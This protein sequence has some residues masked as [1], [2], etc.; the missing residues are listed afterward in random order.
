[1]VGKSFPQPQDAASIAQPTTVGGA[2][3]H[4]NRDTIHA[5]DAAN[6]DEA[7]ITPQKTR[8]NSF[9]SWSFPLIALLACTMTG[10]TAAIAFLSLTALPPE[11]DCAQSTD[12]DT[13]RGLLYCVQR[14][15]QSGEMDKVLEGLE[16]LGQW[17]P[18]DPLYYEAQDSLE[19]WSR[20]ALAVARQKLRNNE[21]D[22]A[23]ALVKKVP[24]S[25][26]LYT[27]AQELLGDWQDQSDQAGMMVSTAQEALKQK[28]W[29]QVSEQ[30]NKLGNLIAYAERLD[31]IRELS[32]Q[33]RV[34]KENN[35][36]FQS[37]L[38]IAE[39]NTPQA[40]GLALE[41]AGTIDQSTYVWSEGESTLKP[42][43]ER[44][45]N[46]SHLQWQQG[47]LGNIIT[48]AQRVSIFESLVPEANNLDTLA[49]AGKLA[50]TTDTKWEPSHGHLFSLLEATSAVRQIPASSQFYDKAQESLKSW[51]AQFSDVSHLQFAKMSAEV[52]WLPTVEWATNQA[53]A[54]STDRP[55]RVQAQTLAAHWNLELERIKDRRRLIWAS[56]LSEPGTRASLKMAITEA[57][58][59]ESDRP[60]FGEAQ[61]LIYGWTRDIQ[62]QEDQPYLAL[63]ESLAKQGEFREA[64]KTAAFIKPNRPLHNAARSA[65]NQWQQE[66]WAQQ[67][68]EQQRLAR[69]RP[70]RRVVQPV[71][72]IAKPKPQ[73]TPVASPARTR[74]R[75]TTPSPAITPAPAPRKRGTSSAPQ[76]P[77]VQ[78]PPAAP[79]QP[80]TPRANSPTPQNDGNTGIVTP[81]PAPTVSTPP[82]S[83]VLDQRDTPVNNSSPS[84]PPITTTPPAPVPTADSVNSPEPEAADRPSV[85][86]PA[87][88]PATPAPALVTP[89][90]PTPAPVPVAAPAPAPA[91]VA[92]PAP[93]PAPSPAPAPAPAPT[94]QV[95]APDSS[96]APAPTSAAPSS[97]PADSTSVSLNSGGAGNGGSGGASE[98]AATQ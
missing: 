17:T 23:I 89:V 78:S 2:A 65:I 26:P 6:V 27:D 18:A 51:E 59:V 80:S 58:K 71:V 13:D 73:A 29:D 57:E 49:K 77:A 10:G 4:D 37:V 16:I 93:A 43:A 42:L 56:K 7:L 86:A 1:M 36:I 30:I 8:E 72:T 61:G 20:R 96:P 12:I 53:R 62:K 81:N 5:P 21:L 52:G 79:A 25:S 97:A 74:S 75:A 15:A 85:S 32:A 34:E 14:A 19:R 54:I 9:K 94:P 3:I 39:A 82:P 91:P 50:I 31:T 67:R 66:I 11:T 69:S 44:L 68:A 60:L 95:Q 55:R 70:R 98:A 76:R 38:Q 90:V 22:E 63:A 64:I 47:H 28:N 35:A 41:K 40:V 33:L 92:A 88:V 46:Y 84:L 83:S 87:P 24:Q 48:T 45:L